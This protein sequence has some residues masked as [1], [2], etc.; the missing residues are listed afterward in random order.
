MKTP[1]IQELGKSFIIVLVSGEGRI[2]YVNDLF[3]K[4]YGF[5]K[6]EIANKNINILNS[7]THSDFFWFDLWLKLKNGTGWSGI[8]KNVN[9][10]GEPIW[11]DKTIIPF[12]DD[13][14]SIGKDVTDKYELEEQLELAEKFSIVGEN[15]SVLLHEVMNKMSIL[16]FGVICIKKGIKNEDKASLKKGLD[17][18]E[19]NYHIILN[20]FNNMRNVLSLQS[21]TKIVNIKEVFNNI[22]ALLEFDFKKNNIQFDIEGDDLNI[23][24]EEIKFN[25]VV[26]NLIKNAYQAILSQNDGKYIKIKLTEQIEW[27]YISIQDSG[28]G[29]AEDNL[30]KLFKKLY[31][32]KKDGTGLGL[33]FC[34]KTLKSIGADLY[35]NKV[36]KSN[37]EFII[38]IPKEH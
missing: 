30:K 37:T 13:F 12:G 11:E 33:H 24:L 38:K 19:K 1:F 27:Y 4:S 29:I 8:I 34:K 5:D 35:Y 6:K 28:K 32:T 15:S 9:K 3:F 26:H 36:N 14:I 17:I 18:I 25:Q 23:E 22:H 16:N 31:T 21:K 2:K 20:I 10:L 7:K